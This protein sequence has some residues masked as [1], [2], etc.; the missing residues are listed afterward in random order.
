M[1]RMVNVLFAADFEIWLS[2]EGKEKF[3]LEEMLT[4]VEIF[5]SRKQELLELKVMRS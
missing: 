4:N 1:L 5:L 3:K 2:L